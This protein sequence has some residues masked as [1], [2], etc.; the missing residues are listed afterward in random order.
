MEIAR[1]IKNNTL[2]HFVGYSHNLTSKNLMEIV[3]ALDD[4][5]SMV[6]LDLSGCLAM[7]TVC[8]QRLATA[9]PQNKS[10]LI[11]LLDNTKLHNAGVISLC[12]ALT[13]NSTLEELSISNTLFTASAVDSISQMIRC[14][15]SL[16][17]LNLADN[18]IGNDGAI[19]IAEALEH[20]TTLKELNLFQCDIG[21][22][23]VGRLAQYPVVKIDF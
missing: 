3:Q 16:K 22:F 10:L 1:N 17:F 11:L 14:N 7:N 21:N 20:N 23:G 8:V 12:S 19:K 4:N 15:H 13:S 6:S 9:L 18:I 5:V 2:D